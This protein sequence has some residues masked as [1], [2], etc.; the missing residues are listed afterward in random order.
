[1]PINNLKTSEHQASKVVGEPPTIDNLGDK[2]RQEKSTINNPK[3]RKGGAQPGNKN[4]LK[5]GLY[6]ARFSDVERHQLGVM[7][8]LESLH[9]IHLLRTLLADLVVLID[10]CQDEDR[11]VK[12][13]NS[14]F[15]GTQRLLFAMR[16]QTFLAGDNRELLTDF[17]QALALFQDEQNI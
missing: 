15:T 3:S 6:A 11:R 2:G 9:E 5:H 12:L 16:T 17:W 10:E 7:P 1:M 14:I 8:P 4:A 13:Y